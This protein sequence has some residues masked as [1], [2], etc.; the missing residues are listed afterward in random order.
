M[1]RETLNPPSFAQCFNLR[2]PVRFADQFGSALRLVDD[3]A[4]R[5]AP[6]EEIEPLVVMLQDPARF[7]VTLFD[8]ALPLARSSK[9]AL[10]GSALGHLLLEPVGA[11]PQSEYG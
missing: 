3:D 5:L 1:V 8:D 6:G 4:V 9:E 10:A 2:P 11:G 7:A